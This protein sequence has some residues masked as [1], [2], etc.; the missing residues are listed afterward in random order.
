MKVQ[1]IKVH[2]SRS[3]SDLHLKAL[4]HD[5]RAIFSKFVSHVTPTRHPLIE[6]SVRD[7]NLV[8]AVISR[9]TLIC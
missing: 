3:T 6:N 4:C 1:I 8:G 5:I 2:L 9:V 7:F